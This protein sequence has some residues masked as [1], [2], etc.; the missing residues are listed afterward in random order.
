MK[1]NI[2]LLIFSLFGFFSTISQIIF[3]R[4]FLVIFFGSEFT[5]GAI[6][7]SWLLWISAGS[8][9]YKRISIY[10]KDK[11]SLFIYV[12][13]AA[14]FSMIPLI[15]VLR[16]LRVISGISSFQ[17]FPYGLMV[18]LTMLIMLIPCA[19][20]GFLFPLGTELYGKNS[21]EPVRG[22]YMWESLGS[23][24]G[25]ALF[26]FFLVKISHIFTAAFL[27]LALTAGLLYLSSINIPKRKPVKIL[28]SL[29]V[30]VFAVLLVFSENINDRF[31]KARWR[32]F[33]AGLEF[34]ENRESK[35][36][37]LNIGVR[38]GQYS[39]F[40]SKNFYFDDW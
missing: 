32:S 10:I 18:L 27:G 24:A 22:I 21:N 12:I 9:L 25:G 20:I 17:L 40:D 15:G 33:A 38:E 29:A 14:A 34:L 37:N 16:N 35:Y 36:E 28:L 4:E 13:L 2:F 5:I 23:M 26:T 19:A 7:M 8:Y 39:V 31:I 1:K 11:Q 3:L 30:L 6:F